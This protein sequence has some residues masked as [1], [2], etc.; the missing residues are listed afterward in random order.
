MTVIG[1]FSG[2]GL[3]I[4]LGGI[5]HLVACGL[6][7]F[8]GIRMIVSSTKTEEYSKQFDPTRGFSLV[9]LSVA[10]SLD[11]LA[12]GVSISVIGLSVWTP[13]IV[14]GLVALIMAYTGTRLGMRA[15]N[16]LG[17]WAERIGGSVLIV[18]GIRIAFEY[19][20]G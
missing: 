18:I 4:L 15:G 8:L 20:Y 9:A 17:P 12:V 7:L 1:W 13:S 14:I 11:A 5:N 10:T 2:E 19:V 6:L 16:I 3:S